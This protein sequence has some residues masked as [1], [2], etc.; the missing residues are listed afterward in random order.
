M[1]TGTYW[2]RALLNLATMGVSV[3]HKEQEVGG[4]EE[5]DL[6]KPTF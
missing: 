3:L 5:E 4:H 6:T 1:E 2:R